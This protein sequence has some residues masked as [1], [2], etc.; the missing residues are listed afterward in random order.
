MKA[1]KVDLGALREKLTNY[2]DIDLVT[3]A[4]DGGGGL[5]PTAGFQRVVERAA[6]YAVGRGRPNRTGG[7][8]LVGIFA[9]TLSPAARFLGEQDMTRHDA[10]NFIIQGVVKGD[11]EPSVWV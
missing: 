4:I 5:K 7:E 2:I 10:I 3:L 1:C 6:H 11:G 9:E 8:L